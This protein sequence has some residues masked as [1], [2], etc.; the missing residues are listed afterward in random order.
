MTDVLGTIQARNLADL[1]VVNRD[2]CTDPRHLRD[3]AHV[4]KGGVLF[5]AGNASG[6]TSP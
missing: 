2:P 3:I 5:E 1:L 6:T 4:I